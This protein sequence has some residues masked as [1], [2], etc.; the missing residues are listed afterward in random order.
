M[1][2]WPKVWTVRRPERMSWD[3]Y[4]QIGVQEDRYALFQAPDAEGRGRLV[5][6]APGSEAPRY[7]FV[8]D[9]I[10][11][12]LGEALAPRQEASARHLDDALGLRDRLIARRRSL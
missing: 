4:V 10:A 5:A 8:E 9:T 1:N 11:Q 12:A 7:L 6:V 3:V 2:E